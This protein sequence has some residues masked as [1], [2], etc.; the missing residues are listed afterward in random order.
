MARTLGEPHQLSRSLAGAAIAAGLKDDFG[1][2][3]VYLEEALALMRARDDSKAIV[4]TLASLAVFALGLADAERASVHLRESIALAGDLGLDHLYIALL[5]CACG[6]AAVRRDWARAVRWHGAMKAGE[7]LLDEQ[8]DPFDARIVSPLIAQ[9]IA[10]LTSD[11]AAA[12]AEAGRALT[13]AEALAEA[14][15]WLAEPG[16]R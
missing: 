6:L 8:V 7:E 11:E 9:A 16:R 12:A 5:L 1:R 2:A 13:P 10:H 3:T 14:G 15:R 4:T